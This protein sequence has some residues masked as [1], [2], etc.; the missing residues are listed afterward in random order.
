MAI[1][2]VQCRRGM[3]YCSFLRGAK[4]S[5]SLAYAATPFRDTPN[6]TNAAEKV[7][8]LQNKRVQRDF[9][10]VPG[11]DAMSNHANVYFNMLTKALN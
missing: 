6:R 2:R 3:H 1:I 9:C 7:H 8:V 5:R 11:L 10:R 4:A